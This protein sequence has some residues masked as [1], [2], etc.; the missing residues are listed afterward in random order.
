MFNA[1][2]ARKPTRRGPGQ[3][4]EE[5]VLVPSRRSIIA[6]Q[7]VRRERMHVGY[8]SKVTSD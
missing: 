8:Y 3:V 4:G 5:I 1:Y 2:C 6:A 7:D